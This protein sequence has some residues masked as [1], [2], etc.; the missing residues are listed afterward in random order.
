M[1]KFS[2]DTRVAVLSLPQTCDLTEKLHN[3]NTSIAKVVNKHAPI[4]GRT[5]QK[6]G[7]VKV[8]WFLTEIITYH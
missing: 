2:K 1:I 5:M 8:E 6:K 7:F 3:Y 4:L